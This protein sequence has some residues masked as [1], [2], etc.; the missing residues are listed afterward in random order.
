MFHENWTSKA[1]FEAHMKMALIQVLMPH[2]NELC[3]RFPNI[4][5][6]EKL[7]VPGEF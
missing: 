2:L 3:E 4:A 6:W 5:I 1:H 7:R